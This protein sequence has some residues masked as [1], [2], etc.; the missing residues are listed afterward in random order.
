[1]DRGQGLGHGHGLADF[2]HKINDTKSK[3]DNTEM[4]LS[5]IDAVDKGQ[6]QN[7]GQ[8]QCQNQGQDKGND[9]EEHL[10]VYSAMENLA[11]LLTDQVW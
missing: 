1:M 9:Q 5:V 6:D 3:A 7:Q 4:P 2:K 11:T 8:G 10:Y